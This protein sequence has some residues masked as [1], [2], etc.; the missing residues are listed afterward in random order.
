MENV[1]QE[2]ERIVEEFEDKFNWKDCGNFEE[3]ETDNIIRPCHKCGYGV[4]FCVNCG[5]DHHVIKHEVAI[6][7]WL[8]TTLPTLIE[9]RNA[10]AREV[11]LDILKVIGEENK[12]GFWYEETVTDIALSHGI[13]LSKVDSK[14]I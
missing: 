13:D 1:N 14:N 6:K 12:F 11:V 3:T 4:Q 10:R 8:R 2:V 7:D 9:D 5:F